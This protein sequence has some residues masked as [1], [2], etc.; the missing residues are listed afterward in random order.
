MIKEREREGEREGEKEGGNVCVCERERCIRWRGKETRIRN[1]MRE[2][3]RVCMC[4]R[5]SK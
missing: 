1:N 3:E 2:R 4:V 5:E